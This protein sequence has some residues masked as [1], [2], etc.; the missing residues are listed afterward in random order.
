[1]LNKLRA[2]QQYSDIPRWPVVVPLKSAELK[3][4]ANLQERHKE[5][6]LSEWM[7]KTFYIYIYIYI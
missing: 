7:T 1:M 3:Q 6:F 4:F 2:K 5:L